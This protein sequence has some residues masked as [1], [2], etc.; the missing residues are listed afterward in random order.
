MSERTYST[1]K[2]QMKQGK[3]KIIKVGADQFNI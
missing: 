3:Q 2:I 1:Y